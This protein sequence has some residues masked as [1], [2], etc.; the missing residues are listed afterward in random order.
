MSLIRSSVSASSKIS[1]LREFLSGEDDF[2][3]RRFW[4]GQSRWE[5][6][7]NQI[8]NSTDYA[9]EDKKLAAMLRSLLVNLFE[10]EEYMKGEQEH[11]DRQDREGVLRLRNDMKE[12]MLKIIELMAE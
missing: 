3:R 4:F 5:H 7:A 12:V 2:G 8:L 9:D 6:P 10:Y 11:M 1:R